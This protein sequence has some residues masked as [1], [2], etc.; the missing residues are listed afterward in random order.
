MDQKDV[1]D[2]DAEDDDD[3]A[4]DEEDDEEDDEEEEEEEEDEVVRILCPSIPFWIILT[5]VCLLRLVPRNAEGV[6]STISL[7]WK[8]V[9][10]RKK[11]K[12]KMRR[13]S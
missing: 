10:T 1:A 12:P 7:K 4:N 8:P 3:G 9:S 5:C 13:M 6:A 11:T 2:D